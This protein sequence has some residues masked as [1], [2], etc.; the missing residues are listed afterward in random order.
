MKSF[1]FL[2]QKFSQRHEGLQS[3][4]PAMLH[5]TVNPSSLLCLLSPDVVSVTQWRLLQK[6]KKTGSTN[7][8]L[9]CSYFTKIIWSIK[10]YFLSPY[11]LFALHTFWPNNCKILSLLWLNRYLLHYQNVFT[12]T[13]KFSNCSFR[14]RS[15][16]TG[17]KHIGTHKTII[18]KLCIKYQK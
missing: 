12:I 6:G 2:N 5:P 17:S 3:A 18:G 11:F 8:F 9:H 14:K 1:L 4:A 16:K 7:V 13:W 15:N 10:T